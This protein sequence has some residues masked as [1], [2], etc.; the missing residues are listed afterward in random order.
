MFKRAKMHAKIIWIV[1]VSR[2]LKG[3]GAVTTKRRAKLLNGEAKLY[4]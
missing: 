3:D 1:R 2:T 4:L